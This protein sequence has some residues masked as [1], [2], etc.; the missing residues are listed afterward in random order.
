[1]RI[2]AGCTLRVLAFF[3]SASINSASPLTFSTFAV[4]GA[5][6]TSLR[7]INE[8]GQ[9]LGNFFDE[10]GAHSFLLDKDGVPTILPDPPGATRTGFDGFNNLGQF[11][12]SYVDE[13][14]VHG[15]L[16]HSGVF[17]TIDHPN[18]VRVLS[19]PGTPTGTG[20]SAVN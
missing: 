20:L 10:A 15:F 12:G 17:T 18:A 11:V 8:L 9:M 4:P 3:V 5:T 13:Q 1:M 14:G 7:R 6:G 19:G 16:Y 2:T